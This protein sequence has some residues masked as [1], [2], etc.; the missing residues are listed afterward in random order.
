MANLVHIII[1]LRIGIWLIN[2]YFE[3]NFTFPFEIAVT[4]FRRK[5]KSTVSIIAV[6]DNDAEV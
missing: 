6:R 3:W 1:I 5:A 2:E 4:V